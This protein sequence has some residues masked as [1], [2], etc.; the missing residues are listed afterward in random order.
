MSNN[1]NNNNSNKDNSQDLFFKV[2]RNI[3]L[4]N[5]IDN[6]FFVFNN[7]NSTT[8]IDAFFEDDKGYKIQKE[9][10]QDKPSPYRRTKMRVNP[11]LQ[12]L[13]LNNNNND[14]NNNNNNN[15]NDNNDN[16]NNEEKEII[17]NKFVLTN[18]SGDQVGSVFS[19]IKLP[20]DSDLLI[21]FTFKISKPQGNNVGA[22]GFAFVIQSISDNQCSSRYSGG[23]TLGYHDIAKGDGCVAVEFDTYRNDDEQNDNHISIQGT[24]NKR[25]NL[26]SSNQFSIASAVPSFSMKDGFE[27]NVEISFNHNETSLSISVDSVQLLNNI[28]VPDLVGLKKAYFGFTGAS[29]YF[30]SKHSILY[31]EILKQ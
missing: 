19:K 3:F 16:D 30:H 6:S 28:H 4:K 21:K 12:H 10:K 23:T 27:H 13:S 25:G 18:D 14:N 2:Y 15:N 17:S 5:K 20:M 22:D 29:G 1:N 8:N 31:C 9:L 7:K 24:N 26:S 11:S